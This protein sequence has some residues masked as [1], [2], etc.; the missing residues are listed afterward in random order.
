M[1]RD[2]HSLVPLVNRIWSAGNSGPKAYLQTDRA[3]RRYL[4]GGPVPSPGGGDV[5]G[6]GG[7]LRA[8]SRAMELVFSCNDYPMLWKKTATEPDRRR[9][10]RRAVKSYPSRRFAPFN[11]D[12]VSRSIFLGYR[13]CL[14]AP[15]PGPLYEPP[16]PPGARG[17][18]APVL[19]VS[20]EMDAVTTPTEGRYVV[21]GFPN[22]RQIIVPDAA[23]VDALYHAKGQAARAIR[24]FLA[25]R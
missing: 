12:E 22:A 13:Y 5:I 18:K 9:Q 11:P 19:V 3:V 16:A 21:A 8:Y 4:T 6:G 25:R 1:R 23:H 15:P 14:T 2:G 10:L 7:G 24:A 17:T 20:G